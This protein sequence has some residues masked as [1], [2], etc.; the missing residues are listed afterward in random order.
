MEIFNLIFKGNKEE[1]IKW[2]ESTSN[3]NVLNDDDNNTLQ[4]ALSFN[5]YEIAN[6]ILDFEIDVNNKNSD[7]QTS[8][9]FVAQIKDI[10]LGKKLVAKGANPNIKD[11]YG[12][13]PLWTATF[14]ARG[15]YE[16]V[17]FLIEVGGDPYDNNKN[18]MS[19]LDFAIQIEDE[20][21]VEILSIDE[22]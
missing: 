7:G 4:Y 11:N 14:N 18:G 1:C 8:M 20:E 19:P 22:K 15:S 2:L 17:K 12:N 10:D 6:M 9:H 3:V 13:S 16:F 21:L 5:Q